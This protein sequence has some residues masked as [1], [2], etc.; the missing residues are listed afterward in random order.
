MGEHGGFDAQRMAGLM[1][2]PA[3]INLQRRA[4]VLPCLRRQ[5]RPRP[6]DERP[7]SVSA[8]HW[9]ARY[10]LAA[11]AVA[12][13][14]AVH[15]ADRGGLQNTPLLIYFPAIVLSG[16]YGGFGPGLLATFLSTFASLAIAGASLGWGRDPGA[17]TSPLCVFLIA[18]I[19][20]SYVN[21]LLHESM[22]ASRQS[23]QRFSL[24][25]QKVR[26]YGVFLLDP[27]GH[28][29][30]WNEAAERITGYSA[31]E[32][33]GKHFEIFFTPEDRKAGKPR[34][35][36]ELAVKSDGFEEPG[37]R[38]RKDGSRFW[39]DAALTALRDERGRLIGFAKVTRDLTE[40]RLAEKAL[41]KTVVELEGFSYT[42]S[43]DLRAPLRAIQGYASIVL[44]REEHKLEAESR[45][46]LRRVA[47]SALRMDRLIQDLLAYGRLSRE[48]YKM[49]ELDLDPIVSHV[50]EH[51]PDIKGADVRV[52]GP[53]GRIC[54]QDSL[55]TLI[56][57]NLL[58]NAVKFVPPG[59]KP[60]VAV[61]VER[62]PGQTRIIIEDNGPGI[63]PEMREKIFQPFTRLRG[64]NEDTGTGIGLAIVRKA[65]ERMGGRVGV[66]SDPGKG[67]RFW[68]ELPAC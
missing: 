67:S 10:I 43:H 49:Y 41:R 14:A 45:D 44:R 39:A 59:R 36:L 34:L 30:T 62:A 38:V 66:D 15:L 1:R 65:A 31:G 63:P 54:G 25:V 22:R 19:S 55:L 5:A 48:D 57:S 51:Y 13:M 17:M 2:A 9:C 68:V 4:R 64:S 60:S 47:G 53:L 26:D 7:D 16:I 21:H 23:E 8:A 18:A 29:A 33:I 24:I 3:L 58:A 27:N 28:V 12:V 52:N 61:S 37:W 56:L 32:I 50:I 40:R 11:A 20:I 6:Q 46:L 35:A 42:V